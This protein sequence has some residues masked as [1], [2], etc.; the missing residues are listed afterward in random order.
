MG[1]VRLNTNLNLKKK[2]NWKNEHVWSTKAPTF[3]CFFFS[4][5]YL[6]GLFDTRQHFHIQ[7][8]CVSSF[9]CINMDI[10]KVQVENLVKL[11][12]LGDDGQ[13][14]KTGSHQDFK[15]SNVNEWPLV[16]PHR[17]IKLWK[18]IKSLQPWAQ[19]ETSRLSFGF[20]MKDRAE[21]T[22]ECW[23]HVS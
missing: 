21:L 11:F 7:I 20:S 1:T 15:R 10:Y 5:L 9:V 2:I 19:C 17:T 3:M 13:K 23:G 18:H 6:H 4:L 12:L 22:S 8:V 14:E 16:K